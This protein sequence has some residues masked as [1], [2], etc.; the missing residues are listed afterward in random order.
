MTQH[1]FEDRNQKT[2]II[3]VLRP[4]EGKDALNSI[5]LVDKRLFK[6]ENKLHAIMDTQTCLWHL[7]MDNGIVPQSF[8]QQFTSFG[9]LLNFVKD[10]YA[11]R[12]VE[13][14]EIQD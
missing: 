1:N 2:D 6:G 11:R 7:K 10:Y 12:N 3:L 4:M 9:K 14:A 8:Q 13:I 5:G